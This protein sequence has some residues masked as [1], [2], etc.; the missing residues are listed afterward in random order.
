MP[1]YKVLKGVAHN[2]G[3][4]FTSLT[5]YAGDD[6]VMGHLLRL[7]RM[8]KLNTLTINLVTGEASPLEL[9]GSPI[10]EAPSW[11]T[12]MFWEL[13]ERHGSERSYVRAATLTL[14]YELAVK[15]A[16]FGHPELIESPY[17]CDVRITDD[18]GKDYMAHFEGWWVPRAA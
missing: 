13:V 14:R 4:S 15:R 16:V 18:R 1:G 2:I 8:T 10:S 12:R 5:N 17:T 7:A 6:Y 9:L 11:Y 3:H